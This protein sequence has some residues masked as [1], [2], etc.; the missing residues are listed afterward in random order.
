MLTQPL[1]PLRAR[2][3]TL[4]RMNRIAF[5]LAALA[6]ALPLAA[7]A[8]AFRCTDA[9]GRVLYT[10]QP[11]TGGELVV[12]AL[13]EEE[14]ERRRQAD[15]E[16][17]ARRAA[18]RQQEMEA[19][20]L[21]LE[22]ERLEIERNAAQAVQPQDSSACRQARE[23][24]ERVAASSSSSA[25]QIR[26]AR[27]NAA[28]ACGQQPPAEVVETTTVVRQPYYNGGYYGRAPYYSAP[29]YG[30][31][32]SGRSGSVSWGVSF[33]SGGVGYGQPRPAPAP[34]PSP[35]FVRP[36]VR[37]QPNFSMPGTSSIPSVRSNL[38]NTATMPGTSSIPSVRT[39][40]NNQ[41]TEPWPPR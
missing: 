5:S 24:A 1:L 15:V 38:N 12:P 34:R 22:R 41:H 29:G 36:Q 40:L 25:E 18:E 14:Q 35:G 16:A 8:Q 26:T 7:H 11:C 9:S 13:T 27:Y 28:L 17:Q 21:R 39:R 37:Q 2:S 23:N 3:E 32:V 30:G 4:E 33:G 6:L 10:D 31:H 20:R 19:E